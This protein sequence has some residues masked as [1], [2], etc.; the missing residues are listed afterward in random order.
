MRRWWR[1]GIALTL[2][3]IGLIVNLPRASADAPAIVWTQYV[4]TILYAQPSY[5]SAQVSGVIQGTGMH[6]VSTSANGQ[7]YQVLFLDEVKSWVPA[8][9]VA[10]TQPANHYEDPASCLLPGLQLRNNNPILTQPGPT[11]LQATG[12]I[13]QLTALMASPD[14]NARVVTQLAPGMRASVEEW[15]GDANGDI[16]YLAHAGGTLGWIWAYAVLFDDPDPATAAVNG[17][18]VWSAASGKGMW[19]KYNFVPVTDVNALVQAAKAAGITHLYLQV[20]ESSKGFFDAKFVRSAR[21]GGARGG[22]QG[23]RGGL[24]LS[25]QCRGGSGTDSRSSRTIARLMAAAPMA[26][27]STSRSAPMRRP[28]LPMAR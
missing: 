6:V 13:T 4:C 12:T 21:A 24:S 18:P 7:W 19:L 28:S 20:A 14:K 22:D 11:P 26:T 8:T 3:C 17:T 25:R 10:A 27:R 1:L 9:D 5:E 23:I 15:A 2:C 16:W